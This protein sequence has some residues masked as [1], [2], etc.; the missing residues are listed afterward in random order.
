MTSSGHSSYHSHHTSHDHCSSNSS[1]RSNSSHSSNR[2]RSSNSNRRNSSNASQRHS[3]GHQDATTSPTRNQELQLQQQKPVINSDHATNPLTR[4]NTNNLRSH[5]KQRKSSP[6]RSAPTSSSM[7][8]YSCKHLA[9]YGKRYNEIYYQGRRMNN[10]TFSRWVRD[11][12]QGLCIEEHAEGF[13]PTSR[14]SLSENGTDA[15]LAREFGSKWDL[16]QSCLALLGTLS[17]A[18]RSAIMAEFKPRPSTRCTSR[19]F[20]AYV[21]SKIPAA[22][23][24]DWRMTSMGDGRPAVLPP[25]RSGATT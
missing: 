20:H 24:I 21:R 4:R 25:W 1:H 3:R 23:G 16:D 7:A 6:T 8:Q 13:R 14:V 2:S 5:R 18:T 15:S 19:L 11:S 22:P 17:V 10:G 12:I 9:P